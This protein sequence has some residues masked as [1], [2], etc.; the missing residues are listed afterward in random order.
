MKQLSL[1]LLLGAALAE[2]ATTDQVLARMDAAG[3]SFRGMS[4]K[5]R[6]ISHTAIIRESQEESGS[7]LLQKQKKS[8]LARID[9]EKPDV[10]SIQFRDRKVQIYLPKLN[11]VQEYDLGRYDSLLSQGLLIGFATPSPELR[12]NY[13]VRLMGEEPIGG[14]AAYRLELEPTTASIKQHFTK[15]EL[16]IGSAE[17]LPL[18]Q[19]LFQP[20]GDYTQIIYSDMKLEPN[21]SDERLRLKLPSNVKREYPQK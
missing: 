20:S 21:L 8:V 6:K 14:Q 12:K 19:R 3:A 9:F 1:L 2:G 15:I 11:V 18:Q 10:R 13:R 17:G 4:A 7:I 16:W 5:L